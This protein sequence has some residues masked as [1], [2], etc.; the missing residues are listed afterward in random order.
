MHQSDHFSTKN[1]WEKQSNRLKAWW[2]NM[3]QNLLLKK[4]KLKTDLLLDLTFS[5]KFPLIIFMKCRFILLKGPINPSTSASPLCLK[6]DF[7]CFKRCFFIPQMQK[8]LNRYL[9]NYNIRLCAI[10]WWI[11]KLSTTHVFCM[12]LSWLFFM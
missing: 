12:I 8:K 7:K 5:N 10:F 6:E 3:V 9:K 11:K 2:I 4:L 1:D